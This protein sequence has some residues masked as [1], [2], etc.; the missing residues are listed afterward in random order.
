MP[1]LSELSELEHA[2]SALLSELQSLRKNPDA[3]NQLAFE[4]NLKA[5]STRYG[6]LAFEQADATR[7]SN[8]HEKAP[9]DRTGS[10][11]IQTP[12]NVALS[13]PVNWDLPNDV[14]S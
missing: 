13:V 4:Q 3:L 14:L 12:Q 9:R 11:D 8:S 7:Q 6:N 5:L 1:H 2:L 10:G